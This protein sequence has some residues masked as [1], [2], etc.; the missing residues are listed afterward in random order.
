MRCLSQ[1][2]KHI[3]GNVLVSAM[4]VLEVASM[5]VLKDDR[6]FGS[7]WPFFWS[8]KSSFLK[9]IPMIIL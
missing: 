4:D 7:G 8:F 6:Y 9:R 3:V 2:R 1:C 5:D